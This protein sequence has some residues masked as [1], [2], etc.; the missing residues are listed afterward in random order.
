MAERALAHTLGH[1]LRIFLRFNGSY[2]LL[3]DGDRDGLLA[4]LKRAVLWDFDSFDAHNYL[5]SHTSCSAPS[6]GQHIPW[7]Q[8]L[9]LALPGIGRDT[10][11]F[12][13]FGVS[14]A[15]KRYALSSSVKYKDFSYY[16][17]FPYCR[18]AMT[19]RLIWPFFIA[20]KRASWSG[21]SKARFKCMP[22]HSRRLRYD[23]FCAFKYCLLP[24]PSTIVHEFITTRVRW[25]LP[26]RRWKR[27]DQTGIFVITAMAQCYCVSSFRL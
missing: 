15:K 17:V 25:S 26:T 24:P 5:S 2:S 22:S 7:I 21:S 27:N 3:K 18:S 10:R 12:G 16:L 20:W 8:G 1:L 11:E 14:Q 13:K 4:G 23:I 9:L 6:I 19:Y